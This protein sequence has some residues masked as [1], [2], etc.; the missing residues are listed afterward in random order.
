MV[1][2]GWTSAELDAMTEAEFG[3][4]YNEAIALEEAKAEAI[5]KAQDK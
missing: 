2:R 4:W 3:Y 1:E 5:R